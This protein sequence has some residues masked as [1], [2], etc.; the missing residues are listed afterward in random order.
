MVSLASKHRAYFAQ[1]DTDLRWPRLAENTP[2]WTV[3]FNGAGY[4]GEGNRNRDAFC[5]NTLFGNFAGPIGQQPGARKRSVSQPIYERVRPRSMAEKLVVSTIRTHNMTELCSNPRMW[6][7]DFIGVD[8][9][10]CDVGTHTA[11]PLCSHNNVEG[12]VV[13]D[14]TSKVLSRKVG[15]GIAVAG[16][17]LDSFHEYTTVEQ[18]TEE[19]E[20]E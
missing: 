3:K 12:C 17:V 20:A 13:F 11:Y 1:L 5:A 4:I 9:V 8:G 2:A 15:A 19:V 10:Y 7:S 18:W 14:E 16:S 6:S